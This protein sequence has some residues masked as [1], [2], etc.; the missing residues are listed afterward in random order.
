MGSFDDLLWNGP[1]R[2]LMDAAGQGNQQAYS[3]LA[4]LRN[5]Y[6]ARA[7]YQA[8]MSMRPRAVDRMPTWMRIDDATGQPERQYSMDEFRRNTF[9]PLIGK[10][11][12]QA[13]EMGG[14]GNSF[15][16]QRISDANTALNKEMAAQGDAAKDTSIRQHQ[17]WQ[18]DWLSDN[19]DNQDDY[20]SAMQQMA[21]FSPPERN[22]QSA[23]P[24]I[25]S[26]L[27]G[28]DNLTGNLGSNMVRAGGRAVGN[29]FG[30]GQQAQSG[31][32]FARYYSQNRWP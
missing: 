1:L 29:M 27:R 8:Q 14:A 18:R 24:Q 19:A 10:V 6:A 4:Q 11:R 16:N 32:P 21:S 22:H 28:A 3:L 17:I 2:P 15:A 12:A 31:N 20:S 23:I 13:A 9:N 30:I 25:L 5:Q 26:A 7:A